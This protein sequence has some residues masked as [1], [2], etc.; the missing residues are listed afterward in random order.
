MYQETDPLLLNHNNRKQSISKLAIKESIKKAGILMSVSTIDISTEFIRVYLFSRLGLKNL[1]AS[2]LIYSVTK[3]VIDPFLVLTNQ[4]STFLAQEYGKIKLLNPADTTISS[5]IYIQNN[6]DEG[7]KNIGTILR[8]GWCLSA[9]SS[10]PCMSLLFF[11][12]KLLE[13]FGV[14][15]EVASIVESYFVPVACGIP[16]IL[17]TNVNERFL[18]AVDRERWLLLS[19]FILSVANIGLNIALIPRFGSLGGGL[20]VLGQSIIGFLGT[21]LFMKLYRDF[22]SFEIFRFR[23]LFGSYIT[24]MLK[25]GLPISIAL[26]I[27]TSSNFL[28][29]IFVSRLGNVRLAI[30]QVVIQFLN[31][32]ITL[33]HSINEG[34]NRIVAQSLGAENFSLMRAV[35]NIGL[36]SSCTFF[37]LFAIAYNI[38]PLK[39]SSI[40][41]SPHDISDAEDLIRYN[42][43]LLSFAKILAVIQDSATLNLSGMEDT[44]FSS[45]ITLLSIVALILPLSAISSYLTNFDVYGISGAIDIGLLVAASLTTGYWLKLSSNAIANN[46]FDTST[47]TSNAKAASCL[48]SIR[49]FKNPASSPLVPR[50]EE[51]QE[52]EDVENNYNP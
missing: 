3:L 21:T 15:E 40:F 41:M 20:A 49:F 14:N 17:I 52:Y 13:L 8:Q 32:P 2:T 1:A 44:L 26:F 38:I 25:Q 42:F 39:L 5:D 4:N 47:D 27:V 36:L 19:H 34:A 24:K 45:L 31:L 51:I 50:V 9:I 10:I 7:S 16:L 12:G 18:T 29:S 48:S 35:G 6:E 30:E 23:K 33:C 28:I 11:S 22:D 43:I 37:S 46:Q